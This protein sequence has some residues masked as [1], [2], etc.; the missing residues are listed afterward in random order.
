MYWIA[1]SMRLSSPAVLQG[2]LNQLSTDVAVKKLIDEFVYAWNK[3][4]VKLFSELFAEDGER[5][6][7][8]GYLM[9]SKEEIERM[10]AFPFLQLC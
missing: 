8:F 9:N 3:H 1:R 4:N 5:T 7:V 2:E 10:H 6:D